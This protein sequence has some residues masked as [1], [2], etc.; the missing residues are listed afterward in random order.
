LRITSDLPP[1]VSIVVPAYNVAAYIDES[2]N[3][4]F[5]QTFSDYELILVN[6][7][8]PDT[9]QL[10]AALRPYI[11]RICYISQEN[12]GAAE[13]RNA[14]LRVAR[15]EFIAFLDADDIWFPNHLA[16]QVGFLRG[17]PSC[18]L[19]YADGLIF[20]ESELAGQTFM[21]L[22]PSSGEVTFE[23]LITARC[24]VLT[25]TVVAK[26]AAILDVGMFDVHIR[27]GQDYD[28]WLRMVRNGAK[29]AY[30]RK[31]LIRRREHP[32]NLS[33]D[34][35]ARAEREL[36][37]LEGFS[38]RWTL[39]PSEQP[40]VASVLDALR[41]NVSREQAK[42]LLA[43][44]DFARAAAAVRD[45]RRKRRDVKLLF[46]EMFLRVSPNLVRLLF[47]WR[48][49]LRERLRGSN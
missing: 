35:L 23:A 29:L 22:A 4:V 7:G 31:V 15:G 43:N 33:G 40:L 39:T 18:D 17:N 11:S 16:D 27:R 1:V 45:A 24:N 2:I 48:T 20:G 14:A 25:S 26:R 10:E 30:Q 8:S 6:D 12:R 3:S 37:V 36:T 49:S 42:K 34:P 9:D 32:D 19:V 28:L 47:R 5:A 21:K 38:Q 46:V 44:G 41:S 13:A